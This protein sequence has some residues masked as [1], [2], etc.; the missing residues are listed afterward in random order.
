M[1]MFMR[2]LSVLSGIM[3]P[4]LT[5]LTFSSMPLV[6]SAQSCAEHPTQQACDSAVQ[7]GATVTDRSSYE[8]LQEGEVVQNGQIY[9]AGGVYR[10]LDQS[11]ADSVLATLDCE[12]DPDSAAC[13]MAREESEKQTQKLLDELSEQLKDGNI[14]GLTVDPETGV[15]MGNI[16]N[17]LLAYHSGKLSPETEK[18]LQGLLGLKP[19]PVA[20]ET[21]ENDDK[22]AVAPIDDVATLDDEA[23]KEEITDDGEDDLLS[24]GWQQKG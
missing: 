19:R 21:K 20:T 7:A 1:M 12:T 23:D 3:V 5:T 15:A 10:P 8:N 17:V 13:T 6:A 14:K 11:Y 2:P 18:T 4:V 16:G 22:T 24:N 9:G